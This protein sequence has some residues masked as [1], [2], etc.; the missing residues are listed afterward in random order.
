[1]ERSLTSVSLINYRPLLFIAFYLFSSS[2]STPTVHAWAA[3]DDNSSGRVFCSH[4]ELWR[5]IR[6]CQRSGVKIHPVDALLTGWDCLLSVTEMSLSNLK[7]CFSVVWRFV[8][9]CVCVC[10]SI[11]R[12]SADD[13]CNGCACRSSMECMNQ[14]FFS[15]PCHIRFPSP[16]NVYKILPLLDHIATLSHGGGRGWCLV[17]I[18][19][20]THFLNWLDWKG[21]GSSRRA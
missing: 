12:L 3:A 21:T 8:C 6:R 16:P 17:C 15:P 13:S 4:Q 5:D 2:T 11:V 9:V 14:A 19:M 20:K 7:T 10:V 1:M 18:Y